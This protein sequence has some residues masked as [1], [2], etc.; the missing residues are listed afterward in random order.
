MQFMKE[1]NKICM[2]VCVWKKKKKKKKKKDEN[3]NVTKWVK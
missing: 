2:W 1:I 3:V